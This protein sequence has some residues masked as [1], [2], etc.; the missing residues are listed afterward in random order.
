MSTP[1]LCDHNNFRTLRDDCAGYCS[2]YS[3]LLQITHSMSCEFLRKLEEQ[4]SMLKWPHFFL[5]NCVS[6]ETGNAGRP[7]YTV[8]VDISSF[9]G[10]REEILRTGYGPQQ[11]KRPRLY[12]RKQD[13][14]PAT[15]QAIARLRPTLT[16]AWKPVRVSG[17]W[18]MGL[19]GYERIRSFL[20]ATKQNK[21]R[22][23]P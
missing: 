20:A 1:Y 18:S 22:K 5:K 3:D 6:T 12:R 14:G 19:L 9:C 2:D 15:N 16:K 8:L 11:L 17:P 4:A 13:R 21:N 7:R 23:P 10:F